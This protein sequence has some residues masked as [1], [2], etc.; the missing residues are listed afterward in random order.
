MY[1]VGA[2]SLRVDLRGLVA[3]ALETEEVMTLCIACA[4]STNVTV[5]ERPTFNEASRSDKEASI[6]WTILSVTFLDGKINN[7]K[8]TSF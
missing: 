4:T 3:K 5:G 1:L 8:G 7:N 6:N 2:G